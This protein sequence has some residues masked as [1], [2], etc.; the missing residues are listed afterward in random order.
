MLVRKS[1]A[2]SLSLMERVVH[3]M[4]GTTAIWVVRLLGHLR[5]DRSC[6]DA[7]G[8]YTGDG[9]GFN[10]KIRDVRRSDIM[11]DT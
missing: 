9:S 11:W 4:D 2:C 3:R 8:E 7:L 5:S 1:T 10:L 6:L